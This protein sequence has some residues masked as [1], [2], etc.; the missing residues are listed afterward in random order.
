MCLDRETNQW[1]VHAA[2]LTECLGVLPIENPNTGARGG[3]RVVADGD[4][5]M[6]EGCR[7]W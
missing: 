4:R 5:H 6:G 3:G 7:N 2:S 1:V